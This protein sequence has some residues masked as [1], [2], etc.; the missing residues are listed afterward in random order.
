[1]RRLLFSLAIFL[2][3]SVSLSFAQKTAL[4]TGLWSNAANWSPSGVPVA[5][6]NVVIPGGMDVTLDVVGTCNTLKI[7]GATGARLIVRANLVVNSTL[8]STTPANNAVYFSGATGAGNEGVLEMNWN[9]PCTVTVRGGIYN[10]SGAGFRGKVY[11]GVADHVLEVYG[12]I[13]TATTNGILFQKGTLKMLGTNPATINLNGTNAETTHFEIGDGTNAKTV[14][15][16]STTNGFKQQNNSII[17]I[18]NAATLFCGG[19]VLN[20]TGTPGTN[21]NLIVKNGGK[22]YTGASATTGSANDILSNITTM[23]ATEIDADIITGQVFVYNSQTGATAVTYNMPPGTYGDLVLGRIGT[24]NGIHYTNITGTTTRTMRIMG[25]LTATKQPGTATSSTYYFS[26]S[27]AAGSAAGSATFELAGGTSSAYNNFKFDRNG[28]ITFGTTTGTGTIAS[29]Q[30]KL[31]VSGFYQLQ[32]NN[33]ST[34]A[35]F[36]F[37]DLRLTAN[38]QL[39]FDATN[40]YDNGSTQSNP[41]NFLSRGNITIDAG[42]VADF[43]AKANIFYIDGSSA[44]A[45][46]TWTGAGTL[47]MYSVVGAFINSNGIL[48]SSIANI[49]LTGNSNNAAFPGVAPN[50]SNANPNFTMTSGTLTFENGVAGGAGFAEF[51][52]GTGRWTF[53]D[54]VLNDGATLA[55]NNSTTTGWLRVNGNITLNGTARII[56]ATSAVGSGYL[57]FNGSTNQIIGGAGTGVIELRNVKINNAAGVTLNRV[58]DITSRISSSSVSNLD[59][60]LGKIYTSST[61]LL[62]VYPDFAFT[63]GSYN[64]FVSGP[65]RYYLQASGYTL[66]TQA[67]P[68]FPI[69]KVDTFER[70]GL[71]GVT[72]FVDND[73]FDAEYFRGNYGDNLNIS[74]PYGYTPLVKRTS[75]LE[76]WVLDPKAGSTAQGKVRLYYENNYSSRLTDK[77]KDLL[78]VMHYKGGSW[79]DEGNDEPSNSLASGLSG[80]INSDQVVSSFS[81]FTFGTT[82]LIV[83]LLPVRIEYF[84]MAHYSQWNTLQFKLNCDAPQLLTIEIEAS[85]NGLQFSPIYNIKTTKANCSAPFSYNDIDVSKNIFYRLKITD[86]SGNISYSAIVSVKKAS[87]EF[88]IEALLPNLIKQ[89]TT[90]K[91]VSNESGKIHVIVYDVLGKMVSMQTTSVTK[92]MNQLQLNYGNLLPGKYYLKAIGQ[93]VTTNTMSFI[94]Q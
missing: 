38:A 30:P 17:K 56:N 82:D 84:T 14:A 40:Y 85:N 43:G 77:G 59:L 52:A 90:L 75:L 28:S 7:G 31:L 46:Y 45:P 33:T 22:L 42:A 48:N 65:M 49:A 37:H 60:T 16:S 67:N 79:I 80:Y 62:R 15:L 12:D 2:C 51:V 44:G 32:H 21:V 58:V 3:F 50:F 87:G 34:N 57:E 36:R 54:V 91:M 64:S 19:I 83:N 74:N 11:M 41:P 6:D 89:N 78:R 47:K 20:S 9:T 86:P 92:G 73:Y 10:G 35:T 94:K 8:S 1:M 26:G 66:A 72:G 71:V 13:Y 76:Y 68:V 5:T 39:R 18:N 93:F 24:G 63:G 61:N 69:G 55:L 70:I 88:T 4:A 29:Q 53:N 25:N 81:P 23:N 27:S